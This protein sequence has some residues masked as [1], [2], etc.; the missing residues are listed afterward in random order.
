MRRII[1]LQK[2]GPVDDSILIKLKK[3]LK[4]AFKNY[5]LNVKVLSYEL[6]LLY[7]E[8]N[9]FKKQYNVDHIL[10][11]LKVYA[12]SKKFFRILGVI[13]QDIFSK[14]VDFRFGCAKYI[15][16]SLYGVA[17]IS[18]FRLKEMLY[19]R[20]EDKSL[21]ELRILKEALHELGHTFGLSLNEHCKNYCVMNFSPTVSKIEEKPPIFCEKCIEKLES[22]FRDL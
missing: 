6:P 10:N 22:Y 20:D 12:E 16:D 2:I 15:E 1:Y 4:W 9:Q 14:L 7:K 13:N 8:Y 19:D 5:D 3:S 21:F 11:R 18:T 17:L